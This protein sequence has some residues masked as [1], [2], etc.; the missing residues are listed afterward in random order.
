MKN[1]PR[2]TEVIKIE[3]FKITCR[4]NSGEIMVI[5]FEQEFK[6]WKEKGKEMFYPLEDYNNFENVI[7]KDGTLQWYSVLI[8][9]TDLRGSKQTQPLDLDPDILYQ[10][11]KPISHYRLVKNTAKANNDLKINSW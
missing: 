4:W 2:I 7:V 3:P 9:Y 6:E 10:K 11:S 5:D 8:N 1:L